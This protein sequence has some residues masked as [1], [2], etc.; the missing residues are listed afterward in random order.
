LGRLLAALPEDGLVFVLSDHGAAPLVEK[1]EG[2]HRMQG[3][4][5]AAGPGITYDPRL[6]RG[7]ASISLSY[8]E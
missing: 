3:I 8:I 5:I 4:W 2:T 7:S 6:A 1:N